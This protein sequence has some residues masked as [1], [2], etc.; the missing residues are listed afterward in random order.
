MQMKTVISQNVASWDVFSE[1]S[2]LQSS[3]LSILNIHYKNLPIQY[4]E[5]FS[6]VKIENFVGKNM[7]FLIYLFKTL[8]EGTL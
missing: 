3:Y 1:L 2:A 8:I 7:I 6:V 5:I 4:T